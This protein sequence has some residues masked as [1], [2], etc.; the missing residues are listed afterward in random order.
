MLRTIVD[1]GMR[2]RFLTLALAGALLV[3]AAMRAG[4]MPVDTFPEFAAP[5]VEVQTEAPGLAASEVER[6]VTLPIEELLSGVSWLKTLHSE[7]VAGLSSVRLMFEPGTDLM[8]ARQLVQ[9]RLTLSYTIPTS[10]K[11]P[12]MLQPLSSTSRVMM[13][14]LS[15]KDI[16]LIQQS[17]IAQWTIKPK[18]LGVPGVANVAIWGERRR[19]LQVH[20]STDKLR[21]AGVKQEQII[22]SAGDSLYVASLSYLKAS[23][24]G[25]GGW[26]DG[27]NQR[28]EIRHVLPMSAAEDLGKISVDGTKKRLHELTTVVEGHPPMVGDALVDSKP[29]LILVVEKFPGASTVDVSRQVKAALGAMR[30]GLPGLTIDD[31]LFDSAS[32][33]EEAMESNAI[34]AGS[35]LILLLLVLAIMLYS[36]RAAIVA[37]GSIVLAVIAVLVVLSL[38]GTTLNTVMLAGILLALSAIVDEIVTVVEGIVRRTSS[39]HDAATQPSQLAIVGEAVIGLRRTVGYA[40]ASLLLLALPI[41]FMGGLTGA[42]LKPLAVSYMLAVAAGVV[43]A[44]LVTP[45]LAGL[46]LDIRADRG[47]SALVARL[48]DGY[49]R[50]LEEIVERPAGAY[51]AAAVVVVG[52]LA[53]WPALNRSLL[54]EFQ[55]RDLVVRWNAAPGAS[56]PGMTRITTAAV[57][58]LKAIPGVRTVSAHFGRAVTGDQVVAMNSGQIWISIDQAADYDATL[59]AIRATLAEYPVIDRDVQSYLRERIREA[60]TGVAK[61]VVVRIFGPDRETLAA[62]AEEV[63]QLLTRVNGLVDLRI[64]GQVTEPQLHVKVDLAKAAQHGLKPGDVRRA[65]ATLFSG[66]EVGKIFEQQKVFD[67]VVWSGQETRAST[68]GL[69][70]MLVETPAGGHV[71]LSQLA[72]LEV[73]ATPTLIRHE[74]AT[75]YI[76]VT[77]GVAGR[78]IGAVVKEVE[79]R[80]GDIRFPLEHH[81]EILG[82][83]GE[84]RVARTRMLAVAIGSA[85]GIFLL[86]QALTGSWLLSSISVLA[87]LASLAGGVIAAMIFGGEASIG[88]LVAFIGIIAIAVRQALMLIQRLQDRAALGEVFGS[89]LVLESAADRV[90][91][92]LAAALAIVAAL[93][94]FIVLGNVSGLE[95]GRP[96]AIVL[97]GGLV[98]STAMTLLVLPSLIL[99]FASTV[100]VDG[101]KGALK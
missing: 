72:E 37:V 20:V 79:R 4:Q 12:V 14:G 10:A 85:I 83:Y 2:Y 39:S 11:A 53:M 100:T 61:P 55:D 54:P 16:P 56:H 42:L 67:V 36:I 32:Y 78:E 35:A 50:L 40:V 45:A 76:D 68:S 24:P 71:R 38:A 70:N 80:L 7:T 81:P 75:P 69:A 6:L 8:R 26:I 31:Q 86:F 3:L 99:R 63:R 89:R 43:V 21:E 101:V 5:V 34:A 29:G 92:T 90:V 47:E 28:L 77:A 74:R 22:S 62:K 91:P 88:S 18:L 51:A 25:S 13:I 15:S 60:L 65:A 93:L 84:R 46:L 27:P 98:A 59:A 23:N 49:Q 64:Q 1:A 19:Q 94:P 52:A 44:L 82:E 97:L 58:D 87:V 48:K 66:L 96:M 41:Y 17:V 9:E 33:I 30:A 95:I 73:K 57:Q